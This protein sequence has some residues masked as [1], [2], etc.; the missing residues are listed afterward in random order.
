MSALFYIIVHYSS[1]V[2][3]LNEAAHTIC[4]HKYDHCLQLTYDIQKW[5]NQKEF[6]IGKQLNLYE[7]LRYLADQ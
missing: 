3:H 2:N 6:M 4:M 7:H 1:I 5:C